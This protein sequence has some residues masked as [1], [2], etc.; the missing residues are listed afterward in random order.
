MVLG[1]GA[2]LIAGV[3][4]MTGCS[5]ADLKDGGAAGE[6]T[7]KIV[8][9]QS[10]Q[11]SGLAPYA[12]N[13]SASNNAMLQIYEGLVARDLETNEVA[14]R[15]AESWELTD[16]VTWVFHLEEDVT[17][18]DGTSLNA[19]AV[20]Y[21]L[22]QVESNPRASRKSMMEPIADV[23]ALDD[24]TVQITTKEPY[25]P[26]L[27]LL[28]RPQMRIISPDAD[29]NSDLNLH[30]VGTGPYEFVEWVQGDRLTLKA[31][32][33]YWRGRPVADEYIIRQVPDYNT[34]LSMMQS[35]EADFV[36]G[37]PMQQAGRVESMQGVDLYE[38][39]GTGVRYLGMNMDREPMNNVE[40]RRAISM[41]ID[42][43]AYIDHIGGLGQ[44]TDS[45]AGTGTFGY[46]PSSD[47]RGVAYDPDGARE[48]IEDNGWVGESIELVASNAEDT[49]DMATVIQAALVDVGLD[50]DIQLY[51]GP[52]ALE[53]GRAGDHDM[54]IAGFASGGSS[55]LFDTLHSLSIDNGSNMARFS[56]SEFD[57]MIDTANATVDSEQRASIL[58]EANLFAM[59]QMP[60][61]VMRHDMSVVAM[62]EET[63]EMIRL[64]PTGDG[65]VRIVP[66]DEAN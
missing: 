35:G 18:H 54:F 28:S 23:T 30:G 2:L 29:Q 66:A 4:V 44:R 14:P 43:D 55:M 46:D 49:V 50:V 5:A 17:F 57:A 52:T 39:R 24:L 19:D 48:I 21:S 22:D 51:D 8:Q 38:S 60:W 62:D 58:A 32:G 26:L 63:S 25:G 6:G 59:E 13:N 47:D 9:L 16:D 3:L 31:Y 10:G 34:A 12:N 64:G 1:A 37:I 11:I 45:Y 33:D 40:F 65:H 42:R 7:G 20:V 41:A 36:G 53:R 15:L 61:V 56:N 27:D